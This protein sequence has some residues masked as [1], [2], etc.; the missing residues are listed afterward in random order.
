IFA[1]TPSSTENRK[2]SI[3]QKCYIIFVF[4]IL[5]VGASV[6]LYLRRFFYRRF[7]L[8]QLAMRIIMD[9]DLYLH[10]CYSLLI[11]MVIKRYRWFKLIKTLRFVDCP[12]YKNHH[13]LIFISTHIV[14]FSIT[15]FN[16]T[17]WPTIL[18]LGFKYLKQYSV[19]SIQNY[20]QFFYSVFAYI[21]L[22]MIL[23]RYRHQT[24]L[25][26]EKVCT[27]RHLKYLRKIKRNLFFL[28][29]SVDVFND[30]FG[31]IF[32]FN[33]IFGVAKSLIHL[34]L[35][36]LSLNGFRNGSS[37]FKST[38][39]FLADINV[40]FIFWMEFLSTALICDEILKEF[41]KI[42]TVANR[43]VMNFNENDEVE[44]F[45]N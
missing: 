8:M 23:A 9:I 36:V 44:S 45:F 42:L 25:L 15:C 4:L 27:K 39:R 43:L 12:E 5:T 32:L 26:R 29:D 18:A 19:E 11:L 41:D 24:S 28:K 14:F 10:N 34:D 7:S 38:V 31:W 30:I 22:K 40:V 35:I 13:Y 33:I 37:N 6:S 17:V 3:S 20:T 1:L 16:L 21:V 2:P